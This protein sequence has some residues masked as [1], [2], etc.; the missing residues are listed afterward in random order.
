M[1][2]VNSNF[3]IRGIEIN[4]EIGAG[5]EVH[6]LLLSLLEPIIIY[7]F[8]KKMYLSMYTKPFPVVGMGEGG[9][10]FNCQTF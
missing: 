4:H 9:I 1:E 7:P 3:L 10:M 6:Q 8:I 2:P 5:L